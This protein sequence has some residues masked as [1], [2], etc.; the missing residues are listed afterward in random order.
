[1]GTILDT[2]EAYNPFTNTWTTVSPLPSARAQLAQVTE[3]EEKI[4]DF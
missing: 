1:L 2:V 3:F 4:S